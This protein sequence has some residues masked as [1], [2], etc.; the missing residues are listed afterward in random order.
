LT[1]RMQ[2]S[3]ITTQ[4]SIALL[5][6]ETFYIVGN[7]LAAAKVI[8]SP[9]VEKPATISPT[10]VAQP[11][12][13]PP[14]ITW[15]TK[16]N[17]KMLFILQQSELKDP[18]LTDFLKKIVEAIGI[19]FD[20]AGFGI[21]NGPVNL[22]EFEEMPNRYGVVF[23]GDLWMHPNVASTFGDKEVFFTSRLAFLQNDADA[24]RQLWGYLKNLKEMLQ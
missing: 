1:L 7:D 19:P 14:G 4:E 15:R 21:V 8:E 22:R 3:F 23:D 17:S 10:P 16:P 5:Y 9:K 11:E 12:T 13:R 18:I 2:E 24:K 20:T 6:G